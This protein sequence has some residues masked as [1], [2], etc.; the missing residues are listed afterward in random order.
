MGNFLGFLISAGSGALKCPRRHSHSH[1]RQ[2]HHYRRLAGCDRGFV[3]FVR[4]VGL[5]IASDIGIFNNAVAWALL[6]APAKAGYASALPSKELGNAGFMADFALALS[7]GV[8]ADPC[9]SPAPGAPPS[10][11]CP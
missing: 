11:L 9:C 7:Y 8:A 6:L 10:R 5:T 3:R 1:G 2:H 4:V